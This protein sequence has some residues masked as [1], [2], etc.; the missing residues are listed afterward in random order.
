MIYLDYAATSPMREVALEAYTKITTQYYGNA[1]SL[2]EEGWMA[3]Q[4]LENAR[5]MVAR[6]AGVEARGIYFTG[7]GTEANLIGIMSLARASTKRHIITSMA[8]HTSVHA[9]MNA[10]ERMGYRVTRLPLQENGLIDCR[11]VENVIEEDTCLI[12]I[13]HINPEI[14]GVQPI[15]QLAEIAQRHEVLIHVDCV[16]SF[17]KLPLDFVKSIDSFSCSAH[18]VGGPKS[19]GAV[20][21]KPGSNVAP[22]FPGLT[23]EEGL[24]GGTVD[25]A[26]NG[27]FAVAAEACN[28]EHQ[29][30]H[31][32]ALRNVLKQRLTG[33]KYTLLEASVQ[34][35]GICGLL[36][37]GYEGQYVMLRL[38]ERGVMVSTGSACDSSHEAGTKTIMAMG[39]SVDEARQFFR[40]SFGFQTTVNE[41]EILCEFLNDF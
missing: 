30:A 2:H 19:C 40:I 7:S 11:E 20:Y 9:A 27:A 10:L 25:V 21:I 17:A 12:A 22:L 13:Q 18:K 35:P 3:K 6:I 15:A 36:V 4:V 26:A 34:Y 8:E 23:H 16:Q 28:N 5:A 33:N 37:H 1:S 24:R 31:F 38:S 14:G 39:A 41:I 32:T 29:H